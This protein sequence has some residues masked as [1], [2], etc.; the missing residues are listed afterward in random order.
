LAKFGQ[1]E[2]GLNQTGLQ[3]YLRKNFKIKGFTKIQ[4]TPVWG[5]NWTF[6]KNCKKK[7]PFTIQNQTTLAFTNVGHLLRFLKNK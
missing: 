3:F 4:R 1:Q 7:V 6:H 2:K 5:L